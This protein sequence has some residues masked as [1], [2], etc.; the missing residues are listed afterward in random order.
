MLVTAYANYLIY[1]ILNKDTEN[2]R[3]IIHY[4]HIKCGA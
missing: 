4:I 1:F 3:Q 2:A